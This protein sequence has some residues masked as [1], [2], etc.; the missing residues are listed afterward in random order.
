MT[1]T[2]KNFLVSRTQDIQVPQKILGGRNQVSIFSIGSLAL[3]LD[4]L[5]LYLIISD[6]SE[7]CQSFL[8]IV[9]KV[10]CDHMSCPQKTLSFDIGLFYLSP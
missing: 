6:F 7:I 10:Q 5:V 2:N 9:F 4:S 8:V 1:I 3:S